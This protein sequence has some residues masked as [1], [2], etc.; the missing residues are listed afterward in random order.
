MLF[1]AFIS[2]KQND[3]YGLS[4]SINNLK[5][6]FKK[7]N[8]ILFHNPNFLTFFKK[9]INIVH[10][11]GCWSIRLLFFFIISFILKIKIIFS[12]HGM[13][14]E[15]ALKIK[16]IKKKIAL[17]F[18]QNFIVKKSDLIIVNSHV[19]KRE[20][21]KIYKKKKIKIIYH[22][23][24]ISPV[25]YSNN[26]NKKIKF[27]FFSKIHPIKGLLD[28][29]KIWNE[30]NYLKKINLDIYGKIDDHNYFDKIKK[31]IISNKNIN[32]KGSIFKNKI[33]TLSKY[34]VLLLPSKSENFGIVILEA[35][36]AGLFLIL[37]STLPWKFLQKTNNAFLIHFNKKILERKIKNLTLNKKKYFTLMIKKNRKRILKKYDWDKISKEYLNLYFK[38]AN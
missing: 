13:L 21:E 15:Q 18:Y 32:Y 7:K 14:L 20:L 29:V 11:H 25:K 22:G 28:L 8:I 6:N 3:K 36:N 9:K 26:L 17:L 2:E 12:P 16:K 5:K 4:N 35:L 1:V 31:Y 27:V 33:E 38:I 30:S 10:I 23:I 24:K 19:E 34:D 37:S